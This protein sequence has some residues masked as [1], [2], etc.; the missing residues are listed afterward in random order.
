MMALS[1]SEFRFDAKKQNSAFLNW[2]M[3]QCTRDNDVQIKTH[4]ILDSILFLRIHSHHF[5]FAH[6]QVKRH[7]IV[8]FMLESEADYMR[9]LDQ[10]SKVCLRFMVEV[11]LEEG[12]L[13]IIVIVAKWKT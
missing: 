2:L 4:P 10:L 13:V 7:Q 6:M 11:S 5:I 1:F 9:L 3:V 8:K 12:S